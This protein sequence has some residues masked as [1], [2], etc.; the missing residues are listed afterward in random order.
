LIRTEVITCRGHPNVLAKH[1]ST[2]EVTT[3]NFLT[4]RGDCIICVEADK[5]ASSLS[6]EVKEVLR[7]EGYGYLLVST[8]NFTELVKG[9]G[10]AGL[11]MTSTVKMIVRKSSFISDAT[12]LIKADKSAG[13]L[14]RDLVRELRGGVVRVFL[15]ASDLP[16]SND[17]V[18]RVLIDSFP[19]LLR[20]AQ[21]VDE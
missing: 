1:R 21:P 15:V 14:N 11:T 13:D 8:Q 12:I 5:S 2:L 3:E 20:R 4:L 9:R 18:L 19:T 7:S 17:E 10:S 6:S 16:L